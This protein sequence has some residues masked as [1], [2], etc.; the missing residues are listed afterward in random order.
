MIVGLGTDLCDV[1]RIERTLERFGDRF[2]KRLFVDSERNVVERRPQHRASGYAMRFAAKEA[3]AKALG[4]GFRHGVFWRDMVV[5][6][7]P[8]G[9]P[10]LVL[11]GGAR[12]RLDALVPD[13]WTPQVDVSLTDEPP[14][15]YAVVIL[16]A[17]QLDISNGAS[18]RNLV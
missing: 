17:N 14:F 16:S 6:S 18:D 2:V 1:T 12:H 9:K 3:C 10:I 11:G 5:S 15:A 7:L 4:S 8:S 13:G